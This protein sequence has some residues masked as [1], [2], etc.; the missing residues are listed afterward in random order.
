M[1]WAL[2]RQLYLEVLNKGA[3]FYV[4][5][6]DHITVCFDDHKQDQYLW[7]GAYCYEGLGQYIIGRI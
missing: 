4:G 7:W 2:I 1:D 5:K 6:N 3:H